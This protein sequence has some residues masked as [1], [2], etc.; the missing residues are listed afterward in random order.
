V[1]TYGQPRIGD[2]QLVSS[3]NSQ[4]KGRLHRVCMSGDAVP[5]VPSTSGLH[6]WLARPALVCSGSELA[7]ELGSCY[8]LSHSGKVTTIPAG[9]PVPSW[10]R[11]LLELV[12]NYV[13]QLADTA[14]DVGLSVTLPRTFSCPSQPPP[15]SLLPTSHPWPLLARPSMA[16]SSLGTHTPGSSPSSS[17]SPLSTRP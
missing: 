4:L 15:T 5:Y 17:Q 9:L 14:R 11:T 16:A 7:E 3:A 2:S 12:L 13:V 8:L 10:P 1:Y 6:T